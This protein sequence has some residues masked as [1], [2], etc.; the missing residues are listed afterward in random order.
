MINRYFA[1]TNIILITTSVYLLVNGFYA[2][3]TARFDY[4]VMPHSTQTDPMQLSSPVGET[5]PPLSQYSAIVER[6][7]FN[8]PSK[9]ETAAQSQKIDVKNLKRTD[10]KL[11]LWGTVTRRNAVAYAVIEDP[12]T[13]KQN[14]YRTGDSIQNAIVKMILRDKIILSV[15][16]HDEILQMAEYSNSRRIARRPTRSIR[17]RRTLRRAQI[18][19]AVKHLDNLT[20]Q[21]RIRA[22]PEGLLISRIRR[23]S[24]FRKMGLR[25]G[26]II[27][28]IDGRGINSVEDALNL[29]RNFK[30]AQRVTLGLKRRGRSRI[31]D[32]I[33]R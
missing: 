10:M 28:D 17:Q 29:Y 19:S 16:E 9:K 20:T 24:L 27:T 13:R 14:L 4:R 11:K 25:N 15:N 33:I 12:K 31:I 5:R 3:V 6:N 26:D 23:S 2:M 18:E 21:A 32:Y 7:L 1:I 30:S 8:I 22:H